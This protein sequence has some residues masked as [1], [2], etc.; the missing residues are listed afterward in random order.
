MIYDYH[1]FIACKISSITFS[2]VD[3]TND[4]P[5][6]C[7]LS[8]FNGLLSCVNIS[9]IPNQDASHSTMN[10]LSK[11]GVSNIGVEDMAFFKRKMWK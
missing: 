5:L 3:F 11:S 6:N 1:F 8:K 10:V 7:F 2:Y 9:P 4:F